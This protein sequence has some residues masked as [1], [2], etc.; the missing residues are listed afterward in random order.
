[1]SYVALDGSIPS[2]I[3][4]LTGIRD[5]DLVNAPHLPSVLKEFSSYCGD[6]MLV[7][8]NGHRFD[9]S[10]IE[11][12]CRRHRMSTRPV[13]YFDSMWLSRAVWTGGRRL[14]HKL[15]RILARLAVERNGLRRHRAGADAIL[16]AR[17]VVEMG[18]R[19]REERRDE[20]VPVYECRLPRR[21][22]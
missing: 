1:M 19:L 2:R 12:A 16:L 14:S 4:Q 3:T 8:H 10:F 13:S 17:S 9:I 7:A 18:A 11:R 21:R 6:S 15:D 20:T 22:G 5:D